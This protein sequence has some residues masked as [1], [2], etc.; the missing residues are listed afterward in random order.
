MSFQSRIFDW[1]IVYEV[2]FRTFP[3]GHISQRKRNSYRISYRPANYPEKDFRV[4][5]VQDFSCFRTF[6]KIY[7][8]NLLY[9]S[10][11]DRNDRVCPGLL[12]WVFGQR[13]LSLH[14]FSNFLFIRSKGCAATRNRYNGKGKYS[15]FVQ[16]VSETAQKNQN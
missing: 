11:Y 3:T 13:K 2:I 6:F 16:R 10:W 4:P 8:R 15:I 1:A 5:S 9:F 14:Y 7:I 12:G